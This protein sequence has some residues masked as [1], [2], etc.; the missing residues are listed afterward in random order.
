MPG[1]LLDNG[2]QTPIKDPID[3]DATPGAA[4][5]VL[6]R[7]HSRAFAALFDFDDERFPGRIIRRLRSDEAMCQLKQSQLFFASRVQMSHLPIQSN[8]VR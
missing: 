3:S 1:L 4:E 2:L 6:C 7:L 5:R 8:P